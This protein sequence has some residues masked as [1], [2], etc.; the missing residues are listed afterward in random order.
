MSIWTENLE[1]HTL[2]A[3]LST[4]VGACTPYGAKAIYGV[5]RPG[6]AKVALSQEAR[7]VFQVRGVEMPEDALDGWQVLR[8]DQYYVDCPAREIHV[9]RADTPEARHEYAHAAL[10]VSGYGG[11]H[12]EWMRRHCSFCHG[13]PECSPPCAS[14]SIDFMP[15]GR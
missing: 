12:H 8:A 7:Q 10:C 11:G 6:E 5:D 14:E 4:I 9:V 2:L 15:E 3:A 13:S 1:R